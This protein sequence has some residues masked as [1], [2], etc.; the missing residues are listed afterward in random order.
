M[1]FIGVFESLIKKFVIEEE[2]S[3][4]MKNSYYIMIQE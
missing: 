1:S 4:Y 2:M 3:W